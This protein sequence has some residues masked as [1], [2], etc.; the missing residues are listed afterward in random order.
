MFI[1]RTIVALATAPITQ[2]I[3][4]IRI[5]GSQTY[6]IIMQIF[7]RPLPK[8]PPKSPQLIF[9]KIV[10]SQKKKKKKKNIYLK[11][12]INLMTRKR[13]VIALSGGVDSAVSAYL[14]KKKGHE[15][16]AIF[17]QN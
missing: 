5:S 2:N 17:M 7:D 12:K 13:V 1:E 6:S 15:L 14:L 4:L 11:V 8:Y 10:N 16:T 3:A 9:G